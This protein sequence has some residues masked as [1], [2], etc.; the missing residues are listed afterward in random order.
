MNKALSVLAVVAI[1]GTAFFAGQKSFGTVE[2]EHADVI[3]ALESCGG[4]QFIGGCKACKECSLKEYSAGGCSYFKDTLCTLCTPIAHCPTDNTHCTNQYDQTCNAPGCDATYFIDA[5]FGGAKCTKCTRCGDDEYVVKACAMDTDTVCA[6]CPECAENQWVSQVCK[7]DAGSRT[8]LPEQMRGHLPEMPTE[9]SAC[10]ECAVGAFCDNTCQHGDVHTMGA[11]T[12][13]AGCEACTGDM[14][15]S[16]SCKINYQGATECTDCSEC[17]DGEY[18]LDQCEN[19]TPFIGEGGEFQ[20]DVV[21]KDTVCAGCTPA[22]EGEWTVFPCDSLHTSDAVH[23]KCSTC[24]EGEYQFAACSEFADTVCPSC[25]DSYDTLQLGD[26]DFLSGLQYCKKVEGTERSMLRCEATEVEGV[27][28]AGESV[29]GEWSS[30]IADQSKCIHPYNTDRPNCGNWESFCEEGFSGDSCCYHK[31]ENNCGTLTS[32]ER[33]GKR[34]GYIEGQDFIGFCREL[35]DEFP[36]CLAFEVKELEGE[37]E[38]YDC[39]FKAAYTQNEK[40]QWMG[41]DSEYACYSNT[42]RQNNYASNPDTINYKPTSDKMSNRPS[43][44][45]GGRRR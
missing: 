38:Q 29:C 40:K 30:P 39:F 3:N 8:L 10:E 36:D 26:E 25:P 4:D 15:A 19:G 27:I 37:V 33:N 24:K 32:R 11:A 18:I 43:T 20:P 6:S 35:C 22:D 31:H 41:V 17:A 1:L 23:Q 9:C 34:N 28:V 16:D 13:C 45:M 21:G 14:W 44:I 7:F 12:S 5:A 2:Y 42:C